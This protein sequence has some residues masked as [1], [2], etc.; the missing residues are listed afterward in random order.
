MT[1]SSHNILITGGNGQVAQALAH[2]PM[3][4][5]FHVTACSHQE[6]DITEPA[7][8]VRAINHYH[9]D[10]IINTAAYTAVDKAESEP[11]AAMQINHLGTHH[12]AAACKK[13]NIFLIHL[14]TDY[15][16]DGT[17]LTPYSEEDAAH[18]INLYGQSKWQGEQAVREQLENHLIL[19]VSGVFSEYGNNF[20]KTML[21][22]ARENTIMRV[23]SDQ[24]TCPTYAGDIAEAVYSSITIKPASGTYH[25][26]SAEP[27]SWHDFAAAIIN[28]AKT[29]EALRIEQIQ[30][31][32]TA[33]YPTAAKRP[34]FSVLNCDKWKKAT[35]MRQPDWQ[36]AIRLCLERLR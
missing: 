17:Q 24:L 29:H 12:L 18:P 7:S 9:P 31:I 11:D 8:I 27:V 2:H 5:S 36:H 35:G 6:L 10:V 25:F 21:R 20:L 33:D 13:H 14:S 3:A 15:V 34:A 22:L 32:T 19:R 1:Y 23:V 28:E 30:A 26:C 16:F 4:D